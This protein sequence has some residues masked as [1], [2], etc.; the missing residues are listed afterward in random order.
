MSEKYLIPIPNIIRT[1]ANQMLIYRNLAMYM[2]LQPI[3][4]NY[5]EAILD[6]S[7]TD[8]ILLEKKD[9]NFYKKLCK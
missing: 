4:N 8:C 2:C 3:E 5:Y 1:D 9:Y 6:Y 7:L